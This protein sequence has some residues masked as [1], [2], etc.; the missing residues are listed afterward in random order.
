MHRFRP[1]FLATSNGLPSY[2]NPYEFEHT[3]LLQRQPDGDK[4]AHTVEDEHLEPSNEIR[5]CLAV[6]FVASN[7]FQ[8]NDV[9]ENFATAIKE[10]SSLTAFWTLF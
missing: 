10:V 1:A 3:C 5:K 7:H 9:V 6:P 2:Y 4:N 8:G